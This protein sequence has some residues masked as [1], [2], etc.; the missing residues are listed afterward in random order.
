MQQQAQ[1]TKQNMIELS[2]HAVVFHQSLQHQRI[3]VSSAS[4]AV[5]RAIGVEQSYSACKHHSFGMSSRKLCTHLHVV[6]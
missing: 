1:T 6:F 2:V 4:C 5:S 3:L